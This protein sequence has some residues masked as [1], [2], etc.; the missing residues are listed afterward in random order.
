MQA[1]CMWV[2]TD[3]SFTTPIYA[4]THVYD[5]T[6]RGDEELDDLDEDSSDDD[7]GVQ[8]GDTGESGTG[9]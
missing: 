3:F 1:T 5:F 9:R 2:D 4:A 8:G 6:W 7:E